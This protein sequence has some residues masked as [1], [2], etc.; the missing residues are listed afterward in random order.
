MDIYTLISYSLLKINILSPT[1]NNM[2]ILPN[3]LSILLPKLLLR[4]HMLSLEME[5]KG[6]KFNEKTR[7]INQLLLI[8]LL[9]Y[10]C[11]LIWYLQLSY[12]IMVLI[13]KIN[14]IISSSIIFCPNYSTNNFNHYTLLPLHSCFSILWNYF[15]F[16]EYTKVS[17]LDHLAA[18]P[19]P[20]TYPQKLKLFPYFCELCT[21]IK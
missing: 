16:P 11:N 1:K 13:F 17:S 21:L 2:N 8:Q 19:N 7:I 5:K 6:G 3:Q 14:M 10:I 20:K 18:Y 9:Y 15:K 12:D 4:E